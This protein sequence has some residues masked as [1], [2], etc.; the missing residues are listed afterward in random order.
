MLIV[1]IISFLIV[2]TALGMGI[3]YFWA[4]DAFRSLDDEERSKLQAEGLAYEFAELSEGIVHYRLEGPQDGQLVVLVHGFSA[5]S[6]VW[7]DHIAPLSASGYRVL[8][9][10]NYGRG[11]SDHPKGPYNVERTDTLLVELL[12]EL[13][14]DEA[15]HMAGYSMG[16]A[17]TAEFASRHPEKLRSVLLIAPAATAPSP[18]LKKIKRI[19]TPVLGDWIIRVLGDKL[20]FNEAFAS[21]EETPSARQH[22]SAYKYQLGYLGYRR[23]LLSTLRYYPLLE[24]V[25]GSYAKISTLD[26]PVTSIWGEKDTTVPFDQAKTL[27][28]LIPQGRIVSFPD[29]EHSLTY[30][31]PEDVN[32]AM[33]EHLQSIPVP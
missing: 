18:D 27:Q 16:G 5:P 13:G 9:F 29:Y 12:Q 10:D 22:L 19:T 15:V 3:S 32:A 28:R 14:I 8:V 30:A 7:A 23:S 4:G 1:R 21:F 33:L 24:G 11:F 26:I 2:F 25:A 31:Y 6:F 17:I 20:F